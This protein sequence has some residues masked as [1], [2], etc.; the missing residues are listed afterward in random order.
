MRTK[1]SFMTNAELIQMYRHT[2]PTADLVEELWLRIERTVVGVA[3]KPIFAKED[4]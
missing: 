1:Y 4:L 3:R 2:A